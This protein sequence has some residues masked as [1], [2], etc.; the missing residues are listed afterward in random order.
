MK[1]DEVLLTTKGLFPDLKLFAR[2]KVREIYDLGD[3]LLFIATDRVSAFDVVMP[4]GIP[5]KGRVLNALS[6]FWFQKTKHIVDN[7]FITTIV[8][9]YPPECWRYKD[10]LSG[11]S[12]LVKKAHRIDIEAVVRGYL[13]GSA[14]KGYRET[15]KVCGIKL[16]SGL[17]ESSKLEE[18]IFTPATKSDS[19]HDQNITFEEMIDIIINWLWAPKQKGIDFNYSGAKSLSEII[20]SRSIKLFT[21]AAALAEEIG[22]IIADTKFEFGLINGSLVLI[23]EVLTPDSSRFWPTDQYE[24]GHSQPS[25]DKQ[26]LR[27]WLEQSGWDKNSS[28]PPLPPDII[29]KTSEK[30]L[31]ALRR[32]TGIT[33]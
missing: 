15:G 26:F 10:I 2:G 6:V 30:Y 12:M 22:V 1:S 25:F 20:R 24:P 32:L 8:D 14:W 21:F 19:G 31:E 3:K 5:F 23:D 13:G 33:L 4:S 27:D 7:H 11:R 16:P 29:Q 28:P 17:L 18:P 9:E